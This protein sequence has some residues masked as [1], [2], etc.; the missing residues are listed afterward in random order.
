M[1]THEIRI[2]NKSPCHVDIAWV[3]SM[4]KLLFVCLFV[5]LFCFCFC[6]QEVMLSREWKWEHCMVEDRKYFSFPL[7]YC[8]K[9]VGHYPSANG[10]QGLHKPFAF[11]ESSL[12]VDSAFLNY[13]ASWW[14]GWF[15]CSCVSVIPRD[16]L[17]WLFLCYSDVTSLKN[18]HAYLPHRFYSCKHPLLN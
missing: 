13:D 11:M 2:C 12:W 14:C 17:K 18:L 6:F 9:T 1:L 8:S 10:L 15:E 3:G 5:C 7:R 4:V 16:V